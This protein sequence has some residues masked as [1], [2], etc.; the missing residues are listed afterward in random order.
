MFGAR[1]LPEITLEEI[2]ERV[3][4][5]D[6]KLRCSTD[7][8]QVQ[9]SGVDPR[10][11]VRVGPEEH[12]SLPVVGAR[13][14]FSQFLSIPYA[15]LDRVNADMATYI[16]NGLLGEVHGEIK[17]R[18]GER[19]IHDILDARLEPIEPISVVEIAE[20]I[21]GR[22]AQILEWWCS[23]TDFRLDVVS[24][25]VHNLV[26]GDRQVGDISC[27]GLRYTQD[28]R[29]HMMPQV[30]KLI[31]RLICTNGMEI[32]DATAKMDGRGSSHEEFL[33]SFEVTSRR[34]YSEVEADIDHFYQLRD[35]PLGDASQAVLRVAEEQG[36]PERVTT[37]L[38]RL[39]PDMIPTEG[40]TQFD[41]VNLFTNA[42]LE[43][44]VPAGTRRR[45]EAI[46]GQVVMEQSTRCQ[47]CS[48]KV[49]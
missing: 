42:A 21:V 23:N 9:F 37:H 26:E 43:P 3:S 30:Q 16:V 29:K 36:L 15:F 27:G 28:L 41:L 10:V 14:A 31:Y 20:A 32:A 19:G 8:V 39:V 44:G 33:T 7:D 40:A 11:R 25:T 2:A 35:R 34:L 12:I 17:I 24:P 4:P 47:T 38:V 18:H 49:G 6:T 5:P 46:G 1:T 48:A 45:L 13:D 22:E